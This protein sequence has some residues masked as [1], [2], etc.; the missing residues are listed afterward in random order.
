MQPYLDP[1]TLLP[2]HHINE[3][4]GRQEPI[5]VSLKAGRA[6]LGH[7][8][9]LEQRRLARVAARVSGAKQRARISAGLVED[10]RARYVFRRSF[11]FFYSSHPNLKVRS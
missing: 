10:F 9:A 2:T 1:F 7:E 11:P 8:H 6:G 4:A 5:N 3:G